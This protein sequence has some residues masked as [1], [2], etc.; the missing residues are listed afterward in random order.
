[1]RGVVDVTAVSLTSQNIHIDVGYNGMV[2]RY[3]VPSG[4]ITAQ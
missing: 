3:D 2:E 4:V 1:M